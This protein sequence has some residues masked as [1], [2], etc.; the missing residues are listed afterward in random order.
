[1]LFGVHMSIV[2]DRDF[3]VK[4]CCC[5]N[6]T[7]KYGMRQTRTT[8]RRLKSGWQ[9]SVSLTAPVDSATWEFLEWWAAQKDSDTKELDE[10][11]QSSRWSK[12]LPHT[13][14]SNAQP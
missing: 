13:S 12:V 1:V 9:Q 10:S 5:E 7:L 14:D 11:D 8:Y 4:L 3:V 2:A 6:T